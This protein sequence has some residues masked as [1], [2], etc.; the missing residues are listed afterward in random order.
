MIAT[1]LDRANLTT[2]TAARY[3]GVTPRTVRRYIA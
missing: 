2:E 1:L 3:L